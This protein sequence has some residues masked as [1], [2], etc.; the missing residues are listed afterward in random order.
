MLHEINFICKN[1]SPYIEQMSV[2]K[3]ALDRIDPVLSFNAWNLAS[4]CGPIPG[5]KALLNAAR[6]IENCIRLAL[7]RD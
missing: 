7:V 2:Y 4:C 5:Q 1:S 3:D 6:T